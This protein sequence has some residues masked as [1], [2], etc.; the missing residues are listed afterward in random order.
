MSELITSNEK[1]PNCGRAITL[2]FIPSVFGATAQTVRIRCVCQE[3][4]SI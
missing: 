1:C 4:L 2:G 3:E